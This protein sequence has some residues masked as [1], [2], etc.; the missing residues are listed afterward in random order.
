MKQKLDVYA[1][2]KELLMMKAQ[3]QRMELGADIQ[4]V[5]HAFAWMGVL[6]RAASFFSDSRFGGL[7]ALGGQFAQDA[8]KRYP[9]LGLLASALLFRFRAPIAKATL[10]AGLAALVV[11]GAGYWFK[12]K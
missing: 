4:A 3:L 8:F 1:A 10:R 2:R 12:R 7:G 9:R 11:A 5:K 6:G